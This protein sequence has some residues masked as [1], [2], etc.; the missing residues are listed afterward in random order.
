MTALDV[1][2][3]PGFIASVTVASAIHH[4]EGYDVAQL[5]I[6]HPGPRRPNETLETVEDGMRRLAASLH[7]GPADQPPPTIGKRIMIRRMLV[8][9]DYGHDRYVMTL[10][11]PSRDWL[12]LVERGELCRVSLVI[13]PLELGVDQ[14]QH[15]AHLAES[16]ARGLAMWGT[17]HGHRRF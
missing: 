4:A 17:T 3:G 10:P 11:T 9:L 6:T 12:T 7:L 14:A 5:L 8:T 1:P 13:A 2:P 16:L 15:N